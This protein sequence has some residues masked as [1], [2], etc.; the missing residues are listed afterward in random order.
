M[1][2]DEKGWRY[3]CIA[4]VPM[5]VTVRAADDKTHVEHGIFVTPSASLRNVTI[6]RRASPLDVSH[7][8]GDLENVVILGSLLLESGAKMGDDNDHP[9]VVQGSAYV[10]S[11]AIVGGGCH[12]GDGCSIADDVT[13]GAGTRIERLAFLYRGCS[14]GQRCRIMRHATVGNKAIVGDDVS[15]GTEAYVHGGVMLHGD[16]SVPA[17]LIVPNVGMPCRDAILLGVEP[18]RKFELCALVFITRKGESR[19]GI[20]A[21]CR[22]FWTL[23]AAREHWSL[24]TTPERLRACS[25]YRAQFDW[26]EKHWMDVRRC[27]ESLIGNVEPTAD[28]RWNAPGSESGPVAWA[29]GVECGPPPWRS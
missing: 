24:C 9:V 22:F 8:R 2:V 13:V 10:G 29:G 28:D 23:A 19:A 3:D 21:G 7:I 12:L 1:L 27:L 18:V 16:I 15:V 14:V 5:D 20:A 17:R 6:G 4:H 25:W 26:L 11:Q